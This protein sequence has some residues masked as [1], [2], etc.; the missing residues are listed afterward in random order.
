M[1]LWDS[2]VHV[3]SLAS[4]RKRN[5]LDLFN[6]EDKPTIQLSPKVPLNPLGILRTET[7]GRDDAQDRLAGHLLHKLKLP[8]V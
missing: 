2:L 3:D 5:G 1:I 6:C 7:N 8:D 4:W